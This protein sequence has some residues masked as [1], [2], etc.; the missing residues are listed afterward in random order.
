[1]NNDS[2]FPKF[3]LSHKFTDL[4][5]SKPKQN[6][7]KEKHIQAYYSQT[8]ENQREKREG[9]EKSNTLHTWGNSANRYFSSENYGDQKTFKVLK[10]ITVNP[11]FCV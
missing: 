1:M 8:D 9:R 4:S 7:Y 3:S 11:K 6:K 5:S 2:E 10:K